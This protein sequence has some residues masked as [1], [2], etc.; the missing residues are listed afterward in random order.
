MQSM[1]DSNYEKDRG[2]VLFKTGC[3]FIFHV[4]LEEHD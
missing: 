3:N 1:S 4:G 2:E